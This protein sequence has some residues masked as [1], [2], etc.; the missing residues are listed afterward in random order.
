M[1]DSEFIAKTVTRHVNAK[2]TMRFSLRKLRSL[3]RGRN[4]FMMFSLK[5]TEGASRVAEAQLLIAERRAPKN[6]I[7]AKSGTIGERIRFGR[8]C[9]G[10]DSM[11]ACTIFGSMR[12]AEYARNIGMNAKQK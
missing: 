2:S 10:S 8:M 6:M 7:C 9:C 4:G 3:M 1:S 11:F 5:L 12:L